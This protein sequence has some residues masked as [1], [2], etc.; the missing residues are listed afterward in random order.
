MQAVARVVLTVIALN[1]QQYVHDTYRN[2]SCDALVSYLIYRVLELR[3]R[4]RA[5][6]KQM[7]VITCAPTFFSLA[8]RRRLLDCDA[9]G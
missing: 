3:R 9:G 5:R 7:I 4:V 2:K 6:C 8:L 1:M